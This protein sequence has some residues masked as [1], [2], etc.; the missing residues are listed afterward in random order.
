MRAVLLASA[1]ICS[2]IPAAVAS[3]QTTAASQNVSQKFDIAAQPLPRALQQF[4]EATGIQ[5]AYTSSLGRGVRS[6]GVSGE[7]AP[8]E[9]LSRLL[10]GTG[11]TYRFTSS[12]AVVLEKAPQADGVISL[13]TIRVEGGDAS[14]AGQ[15]GDAGTDTISIADSESRSHADREAAIYRGAG[16]SA[17]LSQDSIQRFRGASTGDFLS[18]IAGVMNAEN[19]NSG[20]LDVNIRGLQGQGRVPVVI[21]GALQ[22]ATVYRGYAGMAGRTY[23]DPDLLGGVTIEKGPSA[24]ADASGAV[25][26]LVRARTLNAGDIVA[27]GGT[28]GFV[29]RAG[30]SGNNSEAPDGVKIGG[31]ETTS[32]NFNRPDVLDLRGGSLSVAYGYRTDAF[33]IVAAIVH[34]KL[35]NYYTGSKGLNPD[36]WKGGVNRFSREE[37]VHNTAQDNKSYLLRAVLRPVEGHTFDVSYMRYETEHG[38]MKPSQ[39]MYGPTPY[40]TT[41]EVTVDT[42]TGRYRFKPVDSQLIDFRADLWRT[43]A[44][45][46]TVDPVRL[47]YPGF[48]YNGDMFAATLSERWGLTLSNTSRFSGQAGDLALSY[49]A[50]YDYEDFGKSDDW[51]S[52]NAQYPNKAWDTIREGWRRQY[53]GFVSAEYK[54]APWATFTAASRYLNSVVQDTKAGTSWVQGGV[55]N[56]DEASGWTPVVSAV[57]EPLPGVQLYGRYAE[58]LRTASPFEATEGFSG[59]V[60][61][62]ADLKPEHARNTEIGVN[63]QVSGLFGDDLLQTKLGWF[64]N[65]VK[66]YITLG[67]ERLTAPNGNGTDILVRT[68]IPGVIMRGFEL[69]AKY[70]IGW[71]FAEFS[72]TK[73]TDVTSCSRPTPTQ[74]DTC[75]QGMAQTNQSWF[76]NHIPPKQSTFTTVG[77]RL[78]DEKLVLGLRHSSIRRAPAYTLVDL[79]GSYRLNER[80]SFE[81]TLN[82]IQDTYYVD[83]LTLGEGTA[84]LPGPGRTLRI[85]LVSRLGDGQWHSPRSYE[86]RARTAGLT[87]TALGEFDGDW[88][89]FYAGTHMGWSHY[90][91]KGTTTSGNGEASVVAAS[92]ATDRKAQSAIGGLQVGYNHQTPTGLVIGF[93]LDGTLSSANGRQAFL[94][95]ELNTGR[96]ADSEIIQAEY[97]Y[98]YDGALS[99]RLRVGQAIGRY[100]VYG[101]GGIALIDEKQSRIQG[102][103]NSASASSPFGI[104]TRPYFTETVKETR[105]GWVLGGGTEIALNNRLSLRGE[106]TYTHF[107]DKEFGFARASRNINRSYTAGGVVVPGGVDEAIG[108]KASNSLKLHAVRVAMNYNF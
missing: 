34:R 43:E 70:D 28:Y 41:T 32:R 54:P 48:I 104:V 101:T 107:G 51:E 94:A 9:A 4:T 80:M 7:M 106:Y 10:S 73:Y 19:R 46:F 57:I 102:R 60:N 74:I 96:F 27:P 98:D 17:Y 56:R 69:S 37:Q 82:N 39:L 3:A 40:Q 91:A 84:V 99:A 105:T 92:E 67:S 81:F 13:G 26:G 11:L 66:N 12:N 44:D 33:D 108:R 85:S 63:Y 16:T 31:D 42:Y 76:V 21:D 87:Q 38:E 47:I 30:L 2:F 72:G 78:L 18:G 86:Q 8:V 52:L 5:V 20:A 1:A 90:R 97:R 62:Y 89:G 93:E 24:A 36:E 50:A 25:G 95:S 61:P 22:E 59:S 88:S 68:N 15:A 83:P 14:V 55:I 58:A 64:H 75:V 6:A 79:F 100:L 77:T 53:S 71:L 35:G 49:G 65:D 23:L 103:S 45:S 29:I